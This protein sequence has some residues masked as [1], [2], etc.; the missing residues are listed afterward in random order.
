MHC[1]D[2]IA[3]VDAT[4]G[5]RRGK[6][7]AKGAAASHIGVVYKTLAGHTGLLADFHENGSRD[8]IAGIFLSGVELDDQSS[9]EYGMI[10]GIVLLAVVRMPGMGIVCRD[11]ERTL[12]AL[13]ESFLASA[14]SQRNALEHRGEEGAACTLLC[15][16]AGLFIVKDSQHLGHSSCLR[17]NHR[18]QTC[19]THGEVVESSGRDEL[20]VNAKGASGCGIGEIEVEVKDV[21]RG[22]F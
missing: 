15:L 19:E 6:N 2:G 17:G 10:G 22:C 14:L 5:N 3:H 21:L 8:G 20:I 4:E 7:V 1:Q 18:L 13:I 9:A 16:R 12:H 11:H